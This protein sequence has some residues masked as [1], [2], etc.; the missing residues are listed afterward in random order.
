MA[1]NVNDLYN[2]CNFI[3]RKAQ[4]GAISPDEF[5]TALVSA[6]EDFI[7]QK[8]GLPEDFQVG[9]PFARQQWQLS[10]I[11]TE[12]LKPIFVPPVR[13]TKNTAGYF[14]YPADY[15]RYSSIQIDF[16][17]NPQCC[18]DAG[19]YSERFVEVVSDAE[20]VIRL[21]NSVIR[22]TI[23]YPVA[24]FYKDGIKVAP[25]EITTIKMAYLKQT[26]VPRR[27][28]TVNA[29]DQD[30]YDP[31]TSVQLVWDDSFYNDIAAIILSYYGISIRDENLQAYAQNRKQT[32]I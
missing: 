13:I 5:N 11:I 30:I 32:G 8:T 26:P 14:P 2:F 23:L 10:Q 28:Y 15:K 31:A 24:N 27:G 21:N 7:K 16:T 18:K 12:A 19:E 6:N 9:L 22:P 3:A 29:N 25:Y 4:S 20:W 1:Q 17:D